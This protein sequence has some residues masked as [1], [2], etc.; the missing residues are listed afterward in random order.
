MTATLVDRYVFTALRRVPEQ[1]RSD[2]DRELRASI[3]DAVDARVENGEARDAAIEHALLELGD[4]ELLADQYA[5]R[6]QVLIGPDLFPIWR[7]LLLLLLSVVLPIVVGVVVIAA[8]LD[9]GGVGEVIGAAVTTAL[10]TAVHMAFWTTVVFAVLER[11]GVVTKDMRAAWTPADLPKYEP[12]WL[13][14]GQVAANVVW[15]VLL[16]VVLVLQQFTFTDQPV[17]DPDNWSFWWPFLIA[18]LV[19]E[20]VYAVWLLRRGAWSHTVTVAN[21]ALAVLFWGPVIWLVASHG[22]FN[23]AFIDG[24]DWG[25]IDPLRWLTTV[26]LIVAVVAGLWDIGEVAFKSER[27]RRGLPVPVAG[28]GSMIGEH[29]SAVAAL[30]ALPTQFR[31]GRSDD[32]N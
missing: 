29:G 1:Q 21:A 15:P 30:K 32:D 2:I 26:C 5:G 23:P 7:R 11:T 14:P 31:R 9:E 8:I 28:T 3:D 20:C 13:T 22:F 24:L 10:T 25:T 12:G 4:P 18:V 19:L 6:R 27:S 17:L 16:I